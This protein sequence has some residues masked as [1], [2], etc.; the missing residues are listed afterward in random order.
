MCIK[1]TLV[2]LL[3]VRE[4]CVFCGFC[5]DRQV[6]RCLAEKCGS[7]TGKVRIEMKCIDIFVLSAAIC[8]SYCAS[9]KVVTTECVLT[10]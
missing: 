5:D 9:E 8:N 3:M 2:W 1:S 10:V 6:C 7:V 4:R